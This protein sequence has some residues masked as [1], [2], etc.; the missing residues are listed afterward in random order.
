MSSLTEILISIVTPVYNEENAICVFVDAVESQMKQMLDPSERYEIVFV[1]DGSSDETMNVLRN[2]ILKNKS[3]VVLDLSRN[4]GKEIALTAGLEFARGKA[5][6]PM[7]VDLQDPPEVLPEMLEHWRAGYEVVLAKRIDRSADTVFKRAS[8][9]LFYKIFNKLSDTKIPENVGDFR[10]MD[11]RVIEAL[12]SCPEGERFMKGLFA[13]LGFRETSVSFVR[14]VRFAGE[15][16]QGIVS[17]C[18]LAF[19]GLI[20]FSSFPLRIWSVLGIIMATFSFFYGALIVFRTLYFGVDLPG[21]ASLLTVIL[22]LGGLNMLSIGILGEYIA[23][24]FQETKRRPV[25]LIRE[26]VKSEI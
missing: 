19:E 26:I 4:F 18:K 24:I 2:I 6:V 3:I 14:P 13:W 20:S 17:L 5:V 22:F 9:G 15:G 8:A 16:K 11:R 1:N 21:Y 23:R 12:R 25:Y 10:L 7:D